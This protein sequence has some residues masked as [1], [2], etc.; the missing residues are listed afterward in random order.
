MASIL[1]KLRTYPRGN[2][3]FE[4]GSI[5]RLIPGRSLETG[6][7]TLYGSTGIEYPW[8]WMGSLFVEALQQFHE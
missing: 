7:I 2:R 3:Y 1:S 6:M 4:D 5:E 8:P